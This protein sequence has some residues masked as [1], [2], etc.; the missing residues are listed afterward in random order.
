MSAAPLT[1]EELTALELAKTTL[2]AAGW[3]EPAVALVVLGRWQRLYCLGGEGSCPSW[4]V[5]T[6]RAGFGNQVDSGRT[7]IGLHRV[8]ACIGENAPVGA[9]FKGRIPTGEVVAE[10]AD[11]TPD[12]ITTRILWLDGVQEGFNRGPGVDSRARYIYIH[13][14]PRAH[15]LGQPVSAGC[16][17]MKNEHVIELFA[18]VPA[19]TLVLIEPA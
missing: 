10:G 3:Q 16:I 13:G 12:P 9:V 18:R 14:T 7:P 8:C 19:D 6:G 11:D 17:R 4:P 2:R 15:L 5:S 1:P